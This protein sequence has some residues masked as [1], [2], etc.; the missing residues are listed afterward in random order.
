MTIVNFRRSAPQADGSTVPAEGFFRF[1]PSRPRTI[2]GT[3]DNVITTRPFTEDL[4]DGLVTVDLAPTATGSAW[5]VLESIDGVTDQRYSVLVPD[6]AEPVD[7]T[8]LV[9]VDPGT[10]APA[11]VPEPAWWAAVAEL[12]PPNVAWV[13]LDTDGTPYFSNSQ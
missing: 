12:I 4:V 2:V 5:A 13:Y 9:R 6:S 11:A 7:D 8:D 3:P 1:T 10:L